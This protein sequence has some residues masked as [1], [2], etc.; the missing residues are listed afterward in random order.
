MTSAFKEKLTRGERLMGTVVTL[1]VPEIAEILRLAGFD[2]L[3]VDMEHG[4]MDVREAQ[5]VL[6]AAGDTP[7]VVR[8]PANDA[9]WIKKCLDIGAAGIMV[10]L[11]R[12][13]GD[14][15]DAVR[16]CKYPPEGER[17]VGIARAQGYGMSFTQYVSRA[18][19]EIAL[20]LQIEHIDAVNDLEA[21]V[22]V[23]G[24][25]ALFVGPFDLSASMGKTGRI[26]DPAVQAAIA[27]VTRC[28]Q[29]AGI[30]LGIFSAT[31]EAVAPHLE[32]GYTLAAVGM[33]TMIL[34]HG[35]AE[36][37]KALGR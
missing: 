37:L 25:D 10:P 8:V 3:F 14:A 13:A 29:G 32:N 33:D 34:G 35:V 12:T 23:A 6:A 9:V 2:W 26:S 17:S 22:A 18:N 16:W 15:R 30:A 36:I 20:I 31:A 5:M 21:I 1:P 4:A 19:A 11:I 27:R 24:I 28:A 7:C